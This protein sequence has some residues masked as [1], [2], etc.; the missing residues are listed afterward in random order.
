[1]NKYINN[2]KLLLFIYLFSYLFIYLGYTVDKIKYNEFCIVQDKLVTLYI[3]H[4]SCH[5]NLGYFSI[6]IVQNVWLK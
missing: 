6:L 1:M 5:M 3:F 2:N 4:K